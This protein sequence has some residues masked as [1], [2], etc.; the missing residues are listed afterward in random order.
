MGYYKSNYMAGWYNKKG[1]T[2]SEYRDISR[3]YNSRMKGLEYEDKLREKQAKE[4]Q[5]DD[6]KYRGIV[7]IILKELEKRDLNISYLNLA[8]I[9]KSVLDESKFYANRFS[10]DEVERITKSA[11]RAYIKNEKTKNNDI[12]DVDK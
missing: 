3:R 1:L 6:S 12:S 5:Q 7:H 9:T 8:S 4:N 2:S 11:L 10:D